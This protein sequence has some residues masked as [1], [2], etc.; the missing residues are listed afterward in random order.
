MVGRGREPAQSSPP[1]TH[2]RW[3]KPSR[4]A[5]P[6]ARGFLPICRWDIS[7]DQATMLEEWAWQVAT[8]PP[9]SRCI[10]DLSWA[11]FTMVED[12]FPPTGPCHRGDKV[13][14]VLAHLLA[15]IGACKLKYAA[16]QSRVPRWA[17]RVFRALPPHW[18]QHLQHTRG[19]LA[20]AL[21]HVCNDL[22]P[23]ERS[24]IG[25]S[26]AI[27]TTYVLASHAGHY[28]GKASLQRVHR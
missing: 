10:V 26:E 9:T 21:R 25:S 12:V 11:L 7:S 2:I 16:S 14:R 18:L 8:S 13:V 19:V 1:A 27:S 23:G 24:P 17:A 20:K 5:G 22:S 3:P 15:S 28:I 4:P 6:Q